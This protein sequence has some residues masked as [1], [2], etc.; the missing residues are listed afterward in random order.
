V[1][2]S[3]RLRH[4]APLNGGCAFPR[5]FA[6]ATIGRGCGDAVTTGSN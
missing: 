5:V 2:G 1:V 3:R 6:V 4:V